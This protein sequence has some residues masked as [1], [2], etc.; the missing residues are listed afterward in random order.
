MHL[1]KQVN[2]LIRAVGESM[3]ILCVDGVSDHVPLRMKRNN[4]ANEY[5]NLASLLENV[6]KETSFLFIN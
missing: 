4:L 1:R 2:E 5:I 3:V 6:H